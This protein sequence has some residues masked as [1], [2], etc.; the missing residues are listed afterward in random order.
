MNGRTIGQQRVST[1]VG[2]LDEVVGGG[3]KPGGTYL[4]SGAPGTGKTTLGWH[5]LTARS[6]G[7]EALYVTFAEP[8][9]ELRKNAASSGFDIENIHIID[10]S[11]SADVFARG[12][13]YDLFSSSEV[14]REPTTARIVEAI[15]RYKPSRV[16][17]DSMTSLRFLTSDAFQF[18]RQALSFLRFLSARGAT[19]L[20]TS[21]STVDTPDDELRFI[22]DGVVELDMRNRG[23][24]LRIS[25]FRGSSF[26]KGWHGMVLD[27]TGA[28]VYPR[29]L[30]EHFES[31]LPN[32]QFETHIP[33]LDTML[34]GG[35]ERG[36]VT[37]LSGP[38]GV[39][40]TTLGMQLL[41]TIAQKGEHAA[42]YTFDERT[43]TV[44]RR[45][46]KLGIPARELMA[47]G[48]LIVRAIEPLRY[49]PDEFA[50]LVREDA[51]KYNTAAVM[52]DS[53]SGYKMTIEGSDLLERIHALGRYLQNIGV[54][55]FLVDELQEIANFRAS[56][57]GISYLADNVIFL[58]YIERSVD[59]RFELGRGIGILKKR[60]SDFEKGVR[61]F[62]ITAQGIE[63]G[64]TMPLT[65]LFATAPTI[66]ERNSDD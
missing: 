40:K 1:G 25:K 55:T 3:F 45:C 14:E 48:A 63:I 46:E 50:N 10:L 26:R 19:V 47:T 43:E 38:T 4:L 32:T 13:V 59:G 18:R 56:G 23:W 6:P 27:E 15:D 21:E 17:V 33:T 36:T 58:R 30:P 39:G 52:I 20:V 60:L 54:T 61:A 31:S 22:V 16:F 29:L 24:A 41:S 49:G 37:L 42:L 2:G 34:G 8:E 64:D 5:F 51:E 66:H 12:E 62:E 9:A 65:S 57:I 11:P 44:V 53:V 7:E 35:I 28:K